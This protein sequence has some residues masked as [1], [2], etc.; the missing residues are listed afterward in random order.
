MRVLYNVNSLVTPHLTGIGVYMTELA[1]ALRADVDL[2]GAL[3]ISRYGKRKQVLA[4]LPIPL[5]MEELATRLFPGAF[6]LY[7]GPDFRVPQSRRMKRVVTVHD[8]VTYRP[9]L[10]DPRFE[11]AGQEELGE[12]LRARS[13]DHV[14]VNSDFTRAELLEFFPELAD[15]ITV[16]PLGCDHL[17][18]PDPLSPRPRAVPGGEPYFLWVGTLEN[19]KNVPRALEAFARFA[20]K[21]KEFRL[22]LV[23]NEGYGG[24]EILKKA[25]A[26]PSVIR[27]G[28]ASGPELR[29]LYAHAT[30]LFFPSLYEG[31]GVPILEAMRA[32]CPV[33]TS[34]LG[35]M[36]E[37]AGDAAHLV[38]PTS[39][40]ALLGALEKFADDSALRANL[41]RAGQER[42]A[43][44]TWRRTADRTLEGYRRSLSL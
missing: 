31:F 13:P 12:M 18:P 33:I 29:S 9:E 42:A 28:F 19:R 22:V 24:E 10:V 1:R 15:K 21:R 25:A 34:N 32:G 38:D 37:V 3:K 39:T 30:A 2:V 36:K 23:G 43:Y 5:V 7:H 40:E 27:P 11:K 8:L 16:T 41:K 44:F 17:L 4:H 35:A 14:L 20:E 26:M 6:D